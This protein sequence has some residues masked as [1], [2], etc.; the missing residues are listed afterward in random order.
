MLWRGDQSSDC[1]GCWC[2]ARVPVLDGARVGET[3]RLRWRG[4]T[5]HHPGPGDTRHSPPMS[6]PMSCPVM[7]LSLKSDCKCNILDLISLQWRWSKDKNLFSIKAAKP[8]VLATIILKLR[9]IKNNKPAN[10]LI[11]YLMFDLMLCNPPDSYTRLQ[12]LTQSF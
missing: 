9:Y 2:Q 10:V 3:R 7:N 1:S 4:D 11:R 6:G 5:E 8:I 12:I